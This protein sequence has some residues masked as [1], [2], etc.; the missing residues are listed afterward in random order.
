MNTVKVFSGLNA[1]IEEWERLGLTRLTTVGSEGGLAP[2]SVFRTRYVPNARR[3]PVHGSKSPRAH[4]FSAS[5]S[6]KT[7]GDA[8]SVKQEGTSST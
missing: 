5:L 3:C 7:H 8:S 4:T 2:L 1:G 6:K